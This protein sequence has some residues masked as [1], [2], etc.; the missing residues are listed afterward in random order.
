VQR[1]RGLALVLF[2]LGCGPAPAIVP[3]TDSCVTPSAGSVDNVEI[4]AATAAD[5]AGHPTMFAPLADGDG[6]TLLRGAQG[7]TM[8]GFILLVSG[9]QA[10]ACLGQQT[11]VTDAGGARITAVSTPL[12]TYAQ[13]NGTRLTHA[14]WLPADYPAS[15]SVSVAVPG[16][17]LALHLHLM[18]TP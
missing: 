17:S 18:L 11:T 13:P 12:S 4:G 6:V 5:L 7:S 14:L 9:A 2:A 1:T 15:F 10:P 8:L 16:K 3:S